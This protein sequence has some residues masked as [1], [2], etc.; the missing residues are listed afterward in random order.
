MW[1]A[2]SAHLL[3]YDAALS[4]LI[5]L[6]YLL[7]LGCRLAHKVRRNLHA[8]FEYIMGKPSGW[9]YEDGAIVKVCPSRRGVGPAGCI[10][11]AQIY[12][13]MLP[14]QGMGRCCNA[15]WL[16]AVQSAQI[17]MITVCSWDGHWQTGRQAGNVTQALPSILQWL[18]SEVH[19]G[20][21]DG[22][23]WDME[24]MQATQP[25]QGLI[26]RG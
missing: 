8:C 12:S 10:Q 3:D 16:D 17:D 24:G 6:P 21:G 7:H 22:D 15:P 18:T 2:R 14:G 11:A 20:Y 4:V 25:W 26:A 1:S 23:S 9:E 19:T 5:I 13:I